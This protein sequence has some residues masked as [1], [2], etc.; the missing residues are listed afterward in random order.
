MWSR[1]R[2]LW[3]GLAGP[4]IMVSAPATAR[5]A[6]DAAVQHITWLASRALAT[7]RQPNQDLAKRE[8]VFGKLLRQGFDI[9]FI[10]RFVLG[11]YWRRAS[12]EEQSDYLE[13]FGDFLVKT[14]ARRLGGYA[15]ERFAVVGAHEA[16]K[17]DVVVETRIQ[18]P[19]GPAFSAAWR[20]RQIGAHPRIIDVSVEGVSMAVT[21]RQEFG[22]V[23][24]RTGMAGL[25]NLLRA[26]T[27]RLSAVSG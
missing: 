11:P 26:R 4:V 13:L 1:R 15:G 5:I 10:G 14:Y 16:G 17:Q 18:R 21:Q 12:R 7:L 9:S 8:A 27:Q 25:L 23:V 22:A 2:V 3:V 6:T 20:V 19:G 24:N